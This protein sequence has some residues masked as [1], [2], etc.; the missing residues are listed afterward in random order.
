[1][2]AKQEFLR[3]V[4]SVIDTMKSSDPEIHFDEIDKATE[5]VASKLA[6]QGCNIEDMNIV[7]PNTNEYVSGL[8]EI[9]EYACYKRGIANSDR[10]DDEPFKEETISFWNRYAPK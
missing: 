5:K 8:R 9:I 4:V 7:G 1:M 2:E 3:Q 10:E 6:D